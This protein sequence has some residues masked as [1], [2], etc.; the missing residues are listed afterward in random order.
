MTARL[1]VF[2]LGLVLC[3]GTGCRQHDYRT[4]VIKVPDMH[5]EAC[6]QVVARALSRLPGAKGSS[7][8]FDYAARTV[9]IE[10]DTLLASDKNAE[11]LIAKAGLR[12]IAVSQGKPFEIPADPKAAAALPA[13]CRP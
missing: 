5:N 8:K 4:L 13:A 10:Y 6:G 9:A 11:Y 7:L 3:L 1:I 2:A 12:V